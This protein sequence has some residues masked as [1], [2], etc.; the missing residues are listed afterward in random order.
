MGHRIR[1]IGLRNFLVFLV[2]FV[3][4]AIRRQDGMELEGMGSP[5]TGKREAASTEPLIRNCLLGF[6]AIMHI[7][8]I[9]GC[10]AEVCSST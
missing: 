1:V 5:P 7:Y 9:R 3:F 8:V 2:F 6:D 10:V 4:S